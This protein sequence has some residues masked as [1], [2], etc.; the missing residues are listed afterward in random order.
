MFT[1]TSV[2][3]ISFVE[4]LYWFY[5]GGKQLLWNKPQGSSF[6]RKS[7]KHDPDSLEI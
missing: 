4:L 5:K 7:D 6:R 1:L 2:S 3:F